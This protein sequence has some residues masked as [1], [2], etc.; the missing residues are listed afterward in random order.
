MLFT[1]IYDGTGKLTMRMFNFAMLST[2]TL[3]EGKMIRCYGNYT[4]DLM[5]NR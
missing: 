5:V 2:Q 4:L 3:E 1:E